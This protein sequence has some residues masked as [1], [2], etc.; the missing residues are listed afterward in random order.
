MTIGEHG[1]GSLFRRRRQSGNLQRH[2]GV[3]TGHIVIVIMPN[4]DAQ[5]VL[6]E[7]RHRRDI[8]FTS[9]TA[10]EHGFERHGMIALDRDSLASHL[11]EHAEH[12]EHRLVQ[13]VAGQRA[14]AGEIG[15]PLEFERPG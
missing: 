13:A 7:A 15:L 2:R 5:F 4:H 10:S 14:E 1:Q 12:I 6:V 8:R 9:N 11:A 3:G